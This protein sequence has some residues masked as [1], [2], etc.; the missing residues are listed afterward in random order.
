M[1]NS[2]KIAAHPVTGAVFTQARKAD[3]TP[4]LDKNGMEYGQIRLDE[5]RISLD[6]AYN[7]AATKNRS[8][9][10][11]MT[12]DAWKINKDILTVG[13]ELP[14]KIVRVESRT[15]LFEGQ[16]P[17]VN[18]QTNAIVLVDGAKVYFKD[19]YTE[20][21][22]AQDSLISGTITAGEIVAARQSAEAL[23]A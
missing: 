9:F 6:F 23:N 8:A 1:K 13:Q 12:L 18:P 3:G 14:G 17:K 21:L 2:V 5:K 7:K 10:K 22:D 16:K 11:S 4:K 15:P 19:E 20:N